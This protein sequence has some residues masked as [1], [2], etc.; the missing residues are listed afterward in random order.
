MVLL[1]MFIQ[2]TRDLFAIA[3]FLFYWSSDNLFALT[4]GMLNKCFEI[5]HCI[6]LQFN[7]KK[8]HSMFIGKM[9][10]AAIAPMFLN[11][12]AIEWCDRIK[13]LGVYLVHAKSVKFDINPV[14]R[15]FYAACNSIFSHSRG[16]NELVLLSLQE[17]YSLSV[18]MYTSPAL[19][20]QRKQF[21]ELNAC[22][23]SV[24]RRIFGYQ[25][26]ESVKAVLYGLVD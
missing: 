6:Y 4:I 23:N 19:N 8:C 11:E 22:W 20:F 12:Q 26:S 14:K 7:V 16:T 15:S 3:K 2:L 21:G 10:K 25:R 17:S 9:Y 24:I 13:Y 1:L 5:A 18:L